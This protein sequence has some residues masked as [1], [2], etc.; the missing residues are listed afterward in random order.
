[1]FGHLECGLCACAYMNSSDRFF[2]RQA[3]LEARVAIGDM[4]ADSQV[5]QL[6][7]TSAIPV[8]PPGFA[9]HTESSTSI[10]TPV[11]PTADSTVRLKYSFPSKICSLNLI[12]TFHLQKLVFLNPIQ[13]YNRDLSVLA[14]RTWSEIRSEEDLERRQKGKPR[15]HEGPRKRQKKEAHA[16]QTLSEEVRY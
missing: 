13:E 15:R 1:M 10:L 9:I 12:K 6:S 4:D 11:T 2:C 8:L 3:C 16:N 5:D 7:T 14:I